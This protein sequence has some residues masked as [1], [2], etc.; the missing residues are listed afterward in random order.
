MNALRMKYRFWFFACCFLPIAGI[1]EGYAQLENVWVFGRK[2]GINFNG[3]VPA[4]LSSGIVAGERSASICDENGRLL[5]YTS[6]DQVWSRDHRLMPHGD[7]LI[8][9]PVLRSFF[10]GKAFYCRS[11]SNASLIAPIPGQPGRYCL[12]SLTETEMQQYAGRLYYSIID[13]N[14]NSGMG[15]VDINN[16]SVLLDSNLTEHLSGVSGNRCNAW[17]VCIPN[18]NTANGSR[19]KSF[20]ITEVGVSPDP[21]VSNIPG[22]FSAGL[23]F[24]K[25]DVAPNGRKIAVCRSDG[26]R[27]VGYGVELYDFDPLTG[28]FSNP[29]LLS[30]QQT[31]GKECYYGLSFS[32]DGSKIY[33]SGYPM[34]VGGAMFQ[35]DVSK[36]TIEDIISSKTYIDDAFDVKRAPD[37]KLYYLQLMSTTS[38]VGVISR[39]DQPG[40][41]CK[42]EQDVIGIGLDAAF[43]GFPNTIPFVRYDTTFTS[44]THATPC[45][46]DAQL[47]RISALNDTSGWGYEWSDGSQEATTSASRPGVYWVRYHTPPC[48]YHVDTFHVTFP[49]GLLPRLDITSSCLNSNNGR[50]YAIGFAGDTVH[51]AY[52][53]RDKAYTILSLSDSLVGIPAGS[54]TLQVTTYECDTTINFHISEEDYKVSFLLD[55]I[56]CRGETMLFKNRSSDH[57]KHFH[58]LLGDGVSLWKRDAEH[59]YM[60]AGNYELSLIGTGDVC[61]DTASA[62]IIIDEPIEDLYL[63]KSKDF[64]CA[65]QAVRL[66]IQPGPS[67]IALH[68]DFGDGSY[69]DNFEGIVLHAYDVSGSLPLKV[70]AKARACPDV[71]SVDTI[72]VSSFPKVNLGPDSMLCLTGAPLVLV[73]HILPNSSG[74]H[75]YLWSSGEQTKSILV[76]SPGWYSLTVT[77]EAGCATTASVEV[78]KGCYLDV[79]NAFTPNGDGVNDYFFPRQLLSGN[80]VQFRLQVFNRWGQTVYETVRKEGRGW[81]GRFNGKDL[82]GGVYV[83]AISITLDNGF[84]EQYNGNVTLLR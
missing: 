44:N 39:P 21:V 64:I 51:Y 34:G 16:K 1:Y 62:T 13:M 50:A 3:G 69:E 23:Q 24:G 22:I 47:N 30:G 53:W 55:T 35:F 66:A 6:G 78:S 84:T 37:G 17:L 54:Y 29:L 61:T 18:A 4:F 14:L 49:N 43:G 11:T 77:N 72:M 5:F 83:Y 52:T 25:I 32:P 41:A 2:A 81:D 7:T 82:E 46:A 63:S 31:A 71:W 59:V 10:P 26:F 76:I 42:P 56:G 75:R 15:D 57:F 67:M 40:V 27:K 68:W 74:R 65:G 36:R 9:D 79:P 38:T 28:L 45:F 60:Q 58:W 33:S 20:E 48:H 70:T 19:F 80:V 12:F 8:T 73:N